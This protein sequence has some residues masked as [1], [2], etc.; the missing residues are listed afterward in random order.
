MR[1]NPS[2]IRG[3]GRTAQATFNPVGGSCNRLLVG[4]DGVKE[5]SYGVDSNGVRRPEDTG[6]SARSDL[7]ELASVCIP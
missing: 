6:A 1:S 4:Q 7:Q 2:W 3:L 5:G